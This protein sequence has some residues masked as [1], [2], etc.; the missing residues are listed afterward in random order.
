MKF[1]SVTRLRVRSIFYLLPFLR[2]NEAS[3]RELK[4]STGL[5][6]GMELID[7]NLTFWTITMWEDEE[8]MRNFRGCTSHKYAMQQLSR[9]CNEASYHHWMQDDIEFPNWDAVS[10]KLYSQ[11]RLTKVKHPS[12]A[13]IENKFSPI[14]W[15]KTER[16]LK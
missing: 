9:W 12:K 16:I 6:K 5:I 8:S 4:K 1:I 7:K 15:T 11:G 3:V 2:A 14:R 10:E 13:Q